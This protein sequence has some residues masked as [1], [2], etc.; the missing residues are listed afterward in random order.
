M[1]AGPSFQICS[2]PLGD[3]FLAVATRG[4]KAPEQL[5]NPGTPV[6]PRPLGS[7][8][9]LL[10]QHW[11]ALRPPEEARRLSNAPGPQVSAQAQSIC[12]RL[13]D[14][15]PSQVAFGLPEQ[16]LREQLLIS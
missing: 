13:I 4:C 16:H 10:M 7:G 6:Q 9:R 14:Q 11:K 12:W 15:L 5:R 3:P 8:L 2:E 1:P